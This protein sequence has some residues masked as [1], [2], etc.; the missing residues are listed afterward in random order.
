MAQIH[1]QISLGSLS[2]RTR[3]YPFLQSSDV[4]AGYLGSIM[5]FMFGCISSHI[6]EAQ[7]AYCRLSLC[8]IEQ[9]IT[10]EAS[11]CHVSS[12]LTCPLSQSH[13]QD[14]N[15]N[16]GPSESTCLRSLCSSQGSSPHRHVRSIGAVKTTLPIRRVRLAWLHVCHALRLTS[17]YIQSIRSTAN[18]PCPPLNSFSLYFSQDIGLTK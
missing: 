15:F 16:N 4:R 5:A 1:S 10:L 6:V 2:F 11:F 12:F 18:H 14:S 17:Y 8:K 13:R 3:L 9:S 7:R